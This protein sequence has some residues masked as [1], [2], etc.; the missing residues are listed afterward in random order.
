[1]TNPPGEQKLKVLAF[2]DD[3]HFQI[4]FWY[5]VHLLADIGLQV[6]VHDTSYDSG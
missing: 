6:Q 5:Q 2:G 1:M 4:L 3:F